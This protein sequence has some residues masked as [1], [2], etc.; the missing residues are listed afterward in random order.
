MHTISSVLSTIERGDYTF[1]IDLQ[2]AY[3]HVLQVLIHLDSRKY[4][5]FAFE[6]IS[7]STSLWSEH[8]PSGIY[9]SG[10]HRG[11]SPPYQGISVIPYLD[12]WL[13]H[14]PDRQALLRHQSQSHTLD[15]VGLK[16]NEAKS[17]LD[18][19]Q[20]IQGPCA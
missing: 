19:V 18:P 9:S 14:H 4:L 10:I 20:D 11:S 2:D 3:F 6:Y 13:I 15:L 1:K 17:E 7:S 5:H 8:C 12:D 16:L